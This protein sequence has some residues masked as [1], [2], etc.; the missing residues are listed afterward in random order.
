ML[1]RDFYWKFLRYILQ[2]H[3]RER[4]CSLSSLYSGHKKERKQSLDTV[5][6]AQMHSAAVFIEKSFYFFVNFI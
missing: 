4:D 2:K 3:L 5:H 1:A 6:F